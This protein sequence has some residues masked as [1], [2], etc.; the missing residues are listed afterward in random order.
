MIIFDEILFSDNNKTRLQLNFHP[1][2]G[3]DLKD[4]FCWKQKHSNEMGWVNTQSK[5]F[6]VH[7]EFQWMK[8]IKKVN[9]LWNFQWSKS[10][11]STQFLQKKSISLQLSDP[12]PCISFLISFQWTLIAQVIAHFLLFIKLSNTIPHTPFD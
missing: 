2:F 8:D 1:S 10:T 11:V 6:F 7:T 4:D 12:F 3:W 5:F 9:I